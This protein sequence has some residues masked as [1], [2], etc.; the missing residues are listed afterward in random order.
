MIN[1]L[2]LKLLIFTLILSCNQNNDPFTTIIK[3]NRKYIKHLII[4]SHSEV[5][6]IADKETL[7]QIESNGYKLP[8]STEI[9]SKMRTNIITKKRDKNN[10]FFASKE[11]GEMTTTTIINGKSRIEKKPYSEMRILGKYNVLNEFVIDSIIG[12]SLTPQMKYFHTVTI[13]NL[14][15]K[16]KFPANI[17]KVGDTITN[18]E[19][20]TIPMQGMNPVYVIV[21]MEYLLKEIDE[22]KA[23]F[24]LKQKVRL[25]TNWNQENII[26]NGSGFGRS[27]YDIQENQLINY[28]SELPMK[29]TIKINEKMTAKIKINM[30][31]KQTINI[32]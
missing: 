28:T 3:P 30:K 10:E 2:T 12:V 27:V 17:I 24:E 25:D 13:E 20:M 15:K 26:L 8:I 9:T 18:E 1:K 23:I 31:S 19:L 4:S 11:Y 22:N 14:E 5:N 16:I 32:E 29:L 21:K 6:F 7:T